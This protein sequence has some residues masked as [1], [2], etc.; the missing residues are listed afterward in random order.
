MTVHGTALD[1]HSNF[2]SRSAE[3]A[4]A[5]AVVELNSMSWVVAF[6]LKYSSGFSENESGVEGAMVVE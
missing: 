3:K 6:S 4:A 5:G 2:F 1:T